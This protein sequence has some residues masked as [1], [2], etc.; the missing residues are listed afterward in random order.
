MAGNE[1]IP[2][3]HFVVA[4]IP[5]RMSFAGNDDWQEFR[6][7]HD[8][9]ESEDIQTTIISIHKHSLRPS[10]LFR[11]DVYEDGNRSVAGTFDAITAVMKFEA[12]HEGELDFNSESVFLNGPSD[13]RPLVEG[14]LSLQPSNRHPNQEGWLRDCWLEFDRPGTWR[15]A[16]G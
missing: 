3:V 5:Q 11:N 16:E 1:G 14:Y 13:F 4:R 15:D 9:I 2:T 6:D 12:H 7:L 8:E 10:V